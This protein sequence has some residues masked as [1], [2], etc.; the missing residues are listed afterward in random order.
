MEIVA[1]EAGK[2]SSPQNKYKLDKIVRRN[3]FRALEINQH[4]Q[5]KEYFVHYK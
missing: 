1:V 3:H 5:V 2:V 4:K